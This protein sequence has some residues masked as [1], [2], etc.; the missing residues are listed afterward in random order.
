VRFFK[1]LERPPLM[2]TGLSQGNR[3]QV[4]RRKAEGTLEDKIRGEAAGRSSQPLSSEGTCYQISL[5]TTQN[6]P[7]VSAPSEQEKMGLP[8]KP[9]PPF[10]KGSTHTPASRPCLLP[11]PEWGKQWLPCLCG[12]HPSSSRFSHNQGNLVCGT[13]SP[14]SLLLR[15]GGGWSPSVWWLC[16]TPGSLL[17]QGEIREE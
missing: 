7:Q 11:Q 8:H 14:P 3:H 15:V 1:E 10:L 4:K 5:L 2:T 9:L 17:C 13:G 6:Q 12:V 16:F